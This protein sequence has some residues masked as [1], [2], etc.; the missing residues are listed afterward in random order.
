[1][2]IEELKSKYFFTD[3]DYDRF[4]HDIS[5]L[6][7]IDLKRISIYLNDL[8]NKKISDKSDILSE[9]VKKYLEYIDN[10]TEADYTLIFDKIDSIK[11]KQDCKINKNLSI[12]S[13]NSRMVLNIIDSLDENELNEFITSF[14]YRYKCYS[15]DKKLKK[16][17][18]K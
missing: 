10:F 14:Y 7:P 4:L 11:Y 5:S 9:N 12:F 13:D 17:C 6:D 16:Y 15:K 2:S 8:A 1:M 3:F 18:I